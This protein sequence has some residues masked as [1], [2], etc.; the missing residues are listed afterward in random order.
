MGNSKGTKKYCLLLLNI[1]L[2]L[3]AGCG[4]E[5][6]LGQAEASRSGAEE[7]AVV[8]TV[9]SF[10]LDGVSLFAYNSL[11]PSEQ[12]WYRQMEAHLGSMGETVR[13]EISETGEA[14]GTEK[15]DFVFQ[16]VMMD[17]PELFYV[18]GYTYTTYLKEDEVIAIEFAGTYNVSRE[19]A[20]AKREEILR[21]VEPILAGAADFS[22]D[23][24]RV[25]Y[26]YE[27]IITQ[28]EYDL[29]ASDNQNIYS[30]F[31]NHLSVCQG[32]AKAAQYLLNC[33]GVECTLVQG[34]VDTGE[35]HA[36]NLVKVDGGFY[37]VDVTWGD[38]SYRMEEGAR[39][40]EELPKINYDYLCITTKQ[41]LRTHTLHTPVALPECVDMTNNY[42]MRE[43]ALFTAYDREQMKALFRRAGEEGRG[44]VTVK[45]ADEI[46]FA[47]IMDYMIEKQEIFDYLSGESERVTYTHNDK[48]LSMTFLVTNE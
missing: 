10:L 38:A 41:L 5:D 21:R 46:C 23:Y 15:I 33:L 29:A 18:E 39:D 4:R 28:T 1:L 43:G 31:V 17:H 40:G 32:Y 24:E 16:C 13:L 44:E 48:Q 12:I 8:N 6:A 14:L 30:V 9:E 27:T 22:S 25:K 37:Y 7:T 3:L 20:V 45:C 47:E 34:T 42:Y 11:N 36:W 2:V 26:V 19:E 35:D